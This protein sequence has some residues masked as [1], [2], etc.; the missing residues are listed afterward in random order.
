M[1]S[2]DLQSCYI[3]DTLTCGLLPG[4]KREIGNDP[5]FRP[6]TVERIS[7]DVFRVDQKQVIRGA[8]LDNPSVLVRKTRTGYMVLS[9]RTYSLKMQAGQLHAVSES[10]HFDGIHSGHVSAISTFLAAV[11]AHQHLGL[12]EGLRTATLDF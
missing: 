10:T 1:K 11:K 6:L 2:L 8:T 5:A 12:D 9:L 7:K 4:E 3:L